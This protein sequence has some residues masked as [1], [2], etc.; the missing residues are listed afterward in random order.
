VPS[1]YYCELDSMGMRLDKED[2]AEQKYGAYEFKAP[3]SFQT[4]KPVQ[5]RYVFMLDTS[6]SAIQGGMFH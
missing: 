4:S 1:H 6:I 5:P 2:K 3:S